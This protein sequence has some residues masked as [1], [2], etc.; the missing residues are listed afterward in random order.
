MNRIIQLGSKTGKIIS[1]EQDFKYTTIMNSM[2]IQTLSVKGAT[3]DEESIENCL[4][5]FR[6][7]SFKEQ[8]SVGFCF[9][10]N[11]SQQFFAP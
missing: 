6:Y 11:Y 9:V 1:I 7:K 8:K 2:L 10:A 5:K 3:F 4:V